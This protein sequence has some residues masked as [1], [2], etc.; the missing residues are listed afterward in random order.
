MHAQAEKQKSQETSLASG[1]LVI[2]L[3]HKKAAYD[4]W[5]QGEYTRKK[6]RN[7]AHACRDGMRKAKAQMELKL[8]S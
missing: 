1:K 2:E 4:R 5:K 3:Q 7:I 6:F 8:V